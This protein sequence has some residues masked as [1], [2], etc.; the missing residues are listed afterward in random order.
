[1]MELT[2]SQPVLINRGMLYLDW[3]LG[4]P[5]PWGHHLAPT[6]RLSSSSSHGFSSLV[7]H[8]VYTC[9]H[10]PPPMLLLH[11][12]L[13]LQRRS[14]ARDRIHDRLTRRLFRCWTAWSHL[15]P[16]Y[17]L[18]DWCSWLMFV[19][20]RFEWLTIAPRFEFNDAIFLRT[21][22]DRIRNFD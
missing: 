15:F 12:L 5:T 14:L 3:N 9:A 10:T 19:I 17:S 6:S 2:A 18:R 11:V 22:L 20:D 1:M 4:D 13:S 21:W 7:S 16:R 8:R